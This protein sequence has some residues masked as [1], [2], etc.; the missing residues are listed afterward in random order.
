VQHGALWSS[1]GS[2]T[3]VG[4][5]LPRS[6]PRFANLVTLSAS[7]ARPWAVLYFDTDSSEEV[8]P[9]LRNLQGKVSNLARIS[10]MDQLLILNGCIVVSDAQLEELVQGPPKTVLV[11]PKAIQCAHSSSDWGICGS[12]GKG[13]CVACGSTEHL[14]HETHSPI[15]VHVMFQR[16]AKGHE[17]AASKSEL[18]SKFLPLKAWEMTRYW[19]HVSDLKN[20]DR[21]EWCSM[22]TPWIAKCIRR[23]TPEV[24]T[25]LNIHPTKG[26]LAD[27]ITELSVALG[28]PENLEDPKYQR[29]LRSCYDL[30]LVPRK[31]SFTLFEELEQLLA[32][33]LSGHSYHRT[34][35]L[36]VMRCDREKWLPSPESPDK[37]V[38]LLALKGNGKD[39]WSRCRIGEHPLD[40]F[41]DEA[42]M[43]D[44]SVKVEAGQNRLIVV[45]GESG[46]G[47][48][49]GMI[50]IAV[51][52]L[53]CDIVIHVDL[54]TILVGEK[55]RDAFSK[56]RETFNALSKQD[57]DDALVKMI[58]GGLE[59]LLLGAGLHLTGDGSKKVVLILDEVGSFP[60]YARRLC[61]ANCEVEKKLA[62]LLTVKSVRIVCGGTGAD[63]QSLRGSNP[64]QYLLQQIRSPERGKLLDWLAK[65]PYEKC[66][67]IHSWLSSPS[68]SRLVHECLAM[69]SNWRTGTYLITSL[70][71]LPLDGH[72]ERH[73]R[74][75]E[76]CLREAMS[77]YRR[78]NGLCDLR[79]PEAIAT[80]E[81]AL[82]FET[83]ALQ[84][85]LE[86][87]A[88]PE[89]ESEEPP[90]P[91][92][93]L[94][95]S[96]GV[97]ADTWLPLQKP[98]VG[99]PR[100]AMS[101][102]LRLIAV[103]SFGLKGGIA[104]TGSGL[105]N[106][107]CRYFY[108]LFQAAFLVSIIYPGST[109]LLRKDWIAIGNAASE[110]ASK[111]EPQFLH[112]GMQLEYDS[113]DNS[114]SVK[115]DPKTV[116]EK[117]TFKEDPHLLDALPL[118]RSGMSQTH[119]V[120]RSRCLAL[121][122]RKKLQP[123]NK[124]RMGLATLEKER[125]I[126]AELAK[127]CCANVARRIEMNFPAIHE[128]M[129]ESQKTDILIVKNGS[130][131]SFADLLIVN[132]LTKE[133]WLVQ[134]KSIL[135]AKPQVAWAEEL[136]TMGHPNYAQENPDA[137]QYREVLKQVLGVSKVRYFFCVLVAPT[138]KPD[139]SEEI[140]GAGEL[141]RSFTQPIPPDVFVLSNAFGFQFTPMNLEYLN[142]DDP[143]AREWLSEEDLGFA[144]KLVA[145][146]FESLPREEKRDQSLA[147]AYSH[148]SPR[149]K[150]RL[151]RNV[152]YM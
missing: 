147:P 85:P 128:L 103:Q 58:V 30:E 152:V 22:A 39:L 11:V 6:G 46:S 95:T 114:I 141:A 82:A 107:L 43:R 14:V 124:E 111:A 68:K 62:A 8:A 126:L 104:D 144:E 79:V 36:L 116:T 115:P 56:E 92:R 137:S 96:L 55:T 60:E 140:L 2:S 13:Y 88:E 5:P 110:T 29:I 148:H 48:T 31:T 122:F 33:N 7:A 25:V 108:I 83:L 121:R 93:K 63:A 54:P 97:L 24:K 138:V 10:E 123:P 71:Q 23:F 106:E 98:V 65:Q 34:L 132:N 90:N 18:M 81:L 133:L 45:H 131:A 109:I 78:T 139:G 87:E 145:N 16:A 149:R 50:A 72:V 125:K 94:F 151:H 35:S 61:A 102:A 1:M 113:V 75:I 4:P 20:K 136:A 142:E 70:T 42:L 12:C 84:H 76:R 40:Y 112:H 127:G 134:C 17:A 130:M 74:E 19:N 53:A 69:L 57:Q 80:L 86:K 100:Y 64:N 73:P 117:I 146:H 26:L 66:A 135:T 118:T 51:R 21:E 3:F 99:K 150:R 67:M 89:K 37:T 32:S 44:L 77:E 91:L 105:E 27:H 101:P 119:A 47:K 143:E 59:K 49:L 38:F 120:P 28:K 15:A 52:H 9:T 41:V 129:M